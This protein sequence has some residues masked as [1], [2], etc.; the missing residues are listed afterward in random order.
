MQPASSQCM[1][2]LLMKSQR[3]GLA[4]DGSSLYRMML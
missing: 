1:H 2:R 3:M 4:S